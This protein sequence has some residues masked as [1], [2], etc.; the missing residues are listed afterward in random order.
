MS[1]HCTQHAQS[2]SKL[3]ASVSAWRPPLT[4]WPCWCGP[5]MPWAAGYQASK[6]VLSGPWAA[7]SACLMTVT[8][9]WQGNAMN[10]LHHP[11][12]PGTPLQEVWIS[13][14]EVNPLSFLGPSLGSL[15]S[16][17]VFFRTGVRNFVLLLVSVN[18]GLSKHTQAHAFIFCLWLLWCCSGRVQQFQQRLDGS[19]T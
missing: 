14:Q 1:H 8:S 6:Q 13:A 12:A 11:V 18:K 4:Q 16:P 3:I 7:V 9:L 15:L 17:R 19:Q 2:P 5:Y 10:E